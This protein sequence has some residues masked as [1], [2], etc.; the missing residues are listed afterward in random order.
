ME[1]KICYTRVIFVAYQIINVLTLGMINIRLE[2]LNFGK[3][4]KKF[5]KISYYRLSHFISKRIKN[6]QFSDLISRISIKLSSL[7]EVVPLR[8]LRSD[9]SAKL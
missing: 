9:F 1:W 5:Q 3:I 4:K 2:N 8:T 7:S 6:K